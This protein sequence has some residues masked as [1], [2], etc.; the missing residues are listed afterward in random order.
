[1]HDEMDDLG[2]RIA[3]MAASMDAACQRLLADLRRCA[4]HPTWDGAPVDWDSV[5]AAVVD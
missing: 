3:G 4:P 1:M 5:V 2:D